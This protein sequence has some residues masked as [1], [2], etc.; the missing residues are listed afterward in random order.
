MMAC[1]FNLIVIVLLGQNQ[2]SDKLI[3]EIDSFE[4]YKI[5]EIRGTD[6]LD[7][8]DSL[9]ELTAIINYTRKKDGFGK[10]I[11]ESFFKGGSTFRTYYF[12]KEYYLFAMIDLIT[13]SDGKVNRIKYYFSKGELSQAIDKDL[14][15]ITSSVDKQRLYNWIRYMFTKDQIVK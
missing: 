5:D 7:L 6:K 10:V 13:Y 8:R 3:K 1:V 4:K 12:N 2:S 11:E 14:K 9:V 15:N